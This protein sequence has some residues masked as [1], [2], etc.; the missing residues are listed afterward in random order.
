[1]QMIMGYRSIEVRYPYFIG[2]IKGLLWSLSILVR[3]NGLIKR[4]SV[5]NHSDRYKH[6]IATQSKIIYT[7]NRIYYLVIIMTGERF[8]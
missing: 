1:M 7:I 4:L 2:G 8:E 6:G 5:K 3:C